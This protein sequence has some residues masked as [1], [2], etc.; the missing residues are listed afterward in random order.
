[1]A[2]GDM[3]KD[4]DVHHIEELRPLV[5]AEWYAT[6]GIKGEDGS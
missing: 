3:F 6:T 5:G 4:A 2:V 1:M